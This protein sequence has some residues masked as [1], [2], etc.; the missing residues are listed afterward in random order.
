MHPV[1]RYA[2][3][4]CILEMEPGQSIKL[5]AVLG[6]DSSICAMSF[7]S[8]QKYDY[9]SNVPFSTTVVFE[10]SLVP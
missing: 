2:D 9:R 4:P 7:L 8:R 5:L 10:V 1:R 3:D 6:A